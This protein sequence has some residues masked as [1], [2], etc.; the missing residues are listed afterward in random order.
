MPAAK[1]RAYIYTCYAATVAKTVGSA[2]TATELK[3]RLLTNFP[4]AS[5]DQVGLQGFATLLTRT[6]S[7]E[8]NTTDPSGG[9]FEP[10]I[11]SP[12]RYV[13]LFDPSAVS[14]LDDMDIVSM[15][16]N[17][18]EDG[19]QLNFEAWGYYWDRS[20]LNAPGGLRHP[21]SN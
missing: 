15:E 4:D 6:L 9:P 16:R 21:G 3:V 14:P 12:D 20:V 10:L 1:R 7:V 2:K 19:I 13:L 18:N 5:P 11:T 8:T 17:A